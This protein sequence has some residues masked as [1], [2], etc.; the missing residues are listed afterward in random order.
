MLRCQHLCVLKAFEREREGAT[1]FR[2]CV[3]AIMYECL[4][5]VCDKRLK[6]NLIMTQV[7]LLVGKWRLCNAELLPSQLRQPLFLR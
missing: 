2:H 3:T 5:V 1:D 7:M 4:H 6:N